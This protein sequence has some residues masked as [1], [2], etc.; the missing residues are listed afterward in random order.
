MGSRRQVEEW[1]AAGRVLVNGQPAGLG[2]RIRA[3]DEVRVDGR[4]VPMRRL[5]EPEIRVIGYYKPPGVITSRRDPEGRETVFD[6]LPR[7]RQGRWIAVGRLD[8]NTLGLMLFTN[9]GE[10]AHR[11]M[12]PSSQVSREYAVRILGD[13]DA[14]MLRRLTQGV[15]LEDGPAR[16][17]SLSDEGGSGANRWFRVTLHSGRKH[18]VRRLWESQ[19]V[20]VSRLIRVRFGPVEL[21]RSRRLGEWWELEPGQVAALL[22]MAGMEAPP[23]GPAEPRRRQPRRPRGAARPR[24][25]R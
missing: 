15:E 16:F 22:E 19:G 24:R 3:G 23:E 7:P 5:L 6:A 18:E 4:V 14:E 25:R 21:P 13:V 10:L 9:H 8:L 12:H 20:A 1:I 11:L 17:D 2:D